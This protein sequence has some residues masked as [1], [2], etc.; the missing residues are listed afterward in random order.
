MCEEF[1]C[2][3]QQNGICN[4]DDVECEGESCVNW[5]DCGQ[6][7]YAGTGCGTEY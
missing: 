1:E 7:R 4:Y 3:H 6:C 5:N 2:T